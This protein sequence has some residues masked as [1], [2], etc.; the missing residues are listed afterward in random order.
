[1]TANDPQIVLDLIDAFRSSKAMFTAL[2]MGVF[3]LLEKGPDCAAGVAAQIGGQSDAVERLLDACAALGLLSKAEGLYANEPV[4]SA[5]LVSGSPHTLSGYIRYSDQALYPMWGHLADAVR[6]AA[7]RWRQTFGI[8]GAIFSGFFRDPEA[9]RD[10]LRGMHGFGMLTSPKVVEAFDLSRFRRM[11]DLGGATGHLVI[12]ACE[13]YPEL[14]GVVV[15][16]PPVAAIA[17]EHVAR[18]R[19]ADRIE[20]VAADFFAD[21]IPEADLYSVGRVLH[22]W[23]EQKIGALLRKVRLRLPPGGALLVAE[24]LLNE[25]GVGPVPANMQSLNMLI[26]TEGRE[27]SLS[28]YARLLHQAG[29]D[30]VEGRRT[31]TPLDAI[32]AIT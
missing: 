30:H 31:G 12:A 29:F 10:F 3:D 28:E 23:S 19:A 15:D 6:E 24:K 7:P 9:T 26:V 32:L 25:G 16:L 22:D 2:G 1:M 27:R 20:V 21:E 4:A 5:Y 13:R 17:R 14:H 11:V 18:S 8:E